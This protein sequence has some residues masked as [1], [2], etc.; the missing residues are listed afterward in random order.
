MLTP[1]RAIR[2][3]CLDCS[4]GQWSEVARCVIPDC[5][6]YPYRFG[7]N[8]RRSGIGPKNG[9]FSQNTQ[10]QSG[11]LSGSVSN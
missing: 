9:R 2:V 1:L 7:K 6:L 8:P 11:G 4:A 5:A 3:K 10:T